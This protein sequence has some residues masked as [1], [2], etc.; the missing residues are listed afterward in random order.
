[1]KFSS[2]PKLLACFLQSDHWKGKGGSRILVLHT[3]DGWSD[4]LD[5]S[6]V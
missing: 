3:E 1:M 6:G 2:G 4:S 5:V